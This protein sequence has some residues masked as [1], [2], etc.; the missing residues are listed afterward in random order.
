MDVQARRM[1]SGKRREAETRRNIEVVILACGNQGVHDGQCTINSTASVT[2]AYMND[3]Y[4]NSIASS[5]TSVNP[6]KWNGG[7]GYYSD[8]E[9]GLQKVGTRCTFRGWADSLLTVWRSHGA[10][11]P[12]PDRQSLVM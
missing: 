12:D 1:V 4:G 7:S 5:G 2:D 9:S 3:A 10:T 6:K 8:A 11:A